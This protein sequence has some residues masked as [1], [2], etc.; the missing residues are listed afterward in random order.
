MKMGVGGWKGKLAAGGDGIER[1][2]RRPFRAYRLVSIY[3]RLKPWAKFRGSYGALLRAEARDY[4]PS[5]GSPLFRPH[6]LLLRAPTQ[7]FIRLIG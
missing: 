7:L 1:L 2:C 6:T 5:N 3:P 4:Y